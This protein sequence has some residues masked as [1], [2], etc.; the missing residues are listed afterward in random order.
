MTDEDG[1]LIVP[2]LDPAVLDPTDVIRIFESSTKASRLA[3]GLPTDVT[4]SIQVSLNDVQKVLSGFL[5]LAEERM[6][7][8]QF[9]SL[10][11]ACSAMVR[12]QLGA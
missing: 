1:K 10:V 4:G 5:S 9:E 6:P 11:R 12:E 3:I 8:D 2:P 7:E